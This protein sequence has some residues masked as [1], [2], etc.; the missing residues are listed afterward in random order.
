M[1]VLRKE[2]IIFHGDAILIGW[3]LDHAAR[4][5]SNIS[6]SLCDVC[7][8]YIVLLLLHSV[9]NIW[10][11]IFW[12]PILIACAARILLTVPGF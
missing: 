5:Y 11:E 2:G 1:P 3:K 4:E 9:Y 7:Y 8:L 12:G 6:A 10:K